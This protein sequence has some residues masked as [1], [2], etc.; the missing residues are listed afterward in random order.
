MTKLTGI[1]L[2][3]GGRMKYTV[4]EGNYRDMGAA[5]LGKNAVVFTFRGEKE[6]TCA[7]VLVDR[8]TKEVTKIPVP[9]EYCMG[10]LRSITVEL[11]MPE[12]YLYEYE[13]NGKAFLDPYA[14]VIVGRE[15]WNDAK[16]AE[17]NYKVYGAVVAEGVSADKDY[18]PEI[19]KSQMVMY[20]LHVRGFSMDGGTSKRLAGT[21][22]A[23]EER[24]DY[25]QALG[26]T[27][28]ELMPVYEFEEM[29]VPKPKELPEYLTWEK[30]ENDL[31]KPEEEE[32]PKNTKIN[33]WG[34]EPG[35]YFAVKA[36]YAKRPQKAAQEFKH[37]VE[38]LHSRGMECIMEM[39][40]PETENH[41]LILDALRYWVRRFRVDGFHLLGGN[42]PMTAIMQDTLLS[43]TKIF[44][45]DFDEAMID[46]E[47]KY[48]NLYVYKEEYQYPAR[49]IL[50]H[51]NADM[52]EFMNQ[53]KKQ[54]K[55]LGY[56]NY[57]SSNNGF[58]LA[59]VFMYN[60]RHNEDNGENN[61]DGDAWNFSNNYGIEGP[62]RRRYVNQIR[63]KQWRNAVLMVFLA[64][65]V[66]LVWSGD[67]F[68]N[69]QKGNNNA[70]CQDNP[71][72]WINWKKAKLHQKDVEFVKAVCTFRKEH[73]ILSKET[74]FHFSDYRTLGFPD[75]SYHGEN[76]WIC[77][78]DLGKM[79]LGLMYCG[80]YA[81]E[82]EDVYVAYNFYSAV[83][84]LA[85]PKL[86][87]KKKWYL[88]IDSANDSEPVGAPV[89]AKNQQTVAVQPQSICVL[90]GK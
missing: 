86:D 41:N 8:G 81:K 53:Q 21:F 51:I 34:Y 7:V 39:Y 38:A 18:C 48:K 26:V 20:K 60:D 64:Q 59:D 33:F 9:D 62:T 23:V 19:P 67:E 90:V 58:T 35:N 78:F 68:M 43:R 83:S 87:K 5:V 84:T 37:L 6:D 70:Y 49:K 3:A 73:A 69:S 10:S 17:S 25:L 74:P 29:P 54:G 80:A 89:L 45:M 50:N 14:R 57:I 75:V 4:K 1:T 36:S 32:T 30:K 31:I 40:F 77:G 15:V 47:K 16:R 44:Y 79:N 12:K 82:E 55:Q 24:L 28:V 56:V 27:T 65:G 46:P 42:L 85:L 71:I 22:G 63:H 61:V 76:A 72:G 52:T 2:Q 13:I 88:V 11:S 66:P